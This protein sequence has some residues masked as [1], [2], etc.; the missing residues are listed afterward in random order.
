MSDSSFASKKE[1]SRQHV[2][3]GSQ[4]SLQALHSSR[5]SLRLMLMAFDE[6]SISILQKEDA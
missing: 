3:N 1:L 5:A 6:V 2:K 4:Y